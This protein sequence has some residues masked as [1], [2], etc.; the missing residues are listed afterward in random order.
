[1]YC[2]VDKRV[3]VKTAQTCHR[4]VRVVTNTT[5]DMN[6]P[7]FKNLKNYFFKNILIV[8]LVLSLFFYIVP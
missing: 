6:Q 1:M 3:A 2:V 5:V 7:Q 4:I 8:V